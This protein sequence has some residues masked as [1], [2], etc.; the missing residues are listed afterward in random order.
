MSSYSVLDLLH[1]AGTIGRVLLLGEGLPPAVVP[2]AATRARYEV[3]L[4]LLAPSRREL[5]REGWLAHAA[6]TAASALA[7]QGIAYAVMP[8]R[9]RPAARRELVRAGLR[10]S[11]PLAQLQEDETLR[12]LVPLRTQPWRYAF[13]CLIVARPRARRG[14]LTVQTLPGGASLLAALLPGTGIVARRPHADPLASWVSG[15]GDGARPVSDV[16]VGASWRGPAGAALMHCFA[17]GERRPWGVV[18]VSLGRS[19]EA[20]LLSTLGAPARA[21]G[22]RVPRPLASGL[23]PGRSAVAET[24]VAGQPAADLLMRAPAQ[25]ARVAALVAQWLGRWNR[26]TATPAPAEETTRRLEEDILAPA[27]SLGDLLPGGTAYHDRLA[28]RCEVL[29]GAK[30]P[31]VA[32]HNDLSMWNVVLDDRD[33]LGVL[34]WGEAEESGL[35]LT[36]FF[37]AI[38]DAAA[39]CGRYER[40]LEAVRSCY[41]PGGARA[42]GVARNQQLL[43]SGLG[44]SAVA[45]ELCFHACWLRHATNEYRSGV[46]EGPFLGILRDIAR[47]TT[48]SGR[49]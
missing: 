12:Y 9:A 3:D 7:D 10:L 21:A 1:P 15:M 36:D 13:A 32:R 38:A 48:E 29:G 45:V 19:R 31:L 47:R 5:R 33:N 28:R 43:V 39:A 24:V 17:P 27:R 4:A 26:T 20:E 35:P 18:K 37:Y 44:L 8:R 22:A 30:V 2:H 23:L 49:R 41:S 6:T 16:V 46:P 14:L 42:A 40:R 34:D 25:F 11:T